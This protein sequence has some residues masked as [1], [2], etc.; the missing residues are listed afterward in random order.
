MSQ[1]LSLV[2]NPRG[3][4]VLK[5]NNYKKLTRNMHMYTST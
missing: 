5:K 1:I 4:F 3:L 2:K